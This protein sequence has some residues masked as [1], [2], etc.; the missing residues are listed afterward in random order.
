MPVDSAPAGSIPSTSLTP[1]SRAA[2]SP[3]SRGAQVLASVGEPQPEL[4]SRLRLATMRLA[5]LLRQHG[6]PDSGLSPSL[7]SALATVSRTGPITLGRL[8][9]V[10][11]VQPP[12]MTRIVAQLEDRGLVERQTDARDRRIARVRVTPVAE[13]LLA[14]AR[15]R[16]NEYLADR[17]AELTPNELRTIERALPAIERLAGEQR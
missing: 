8:A 6:D 11:R 13:R 17:L 10:E 16:K 7:V 4:T 3:S 5:R 12:S 1:V 14:E 9:E 15:S 2:A